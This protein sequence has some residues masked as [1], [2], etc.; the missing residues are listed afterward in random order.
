[1]D[2][3]E[4]LKR[5]IDQSQEIVVFTGAGISTESGVSDYRSQGGIWQRFQPV[6]IQEFM[7]DEDKRELYWQRKLALFEE[8][9]DAKPNIGHKAIVE[10]ERQGKLRALITQNIDGLHQMAGTDPKKI[11]ELHGT[12]LEVICL[13]C[14][15]IHSWEHAY[16]RLKNGEKAPKCEKCQGLLKPNTISFGQTLDTHVLEQ[17]FKHASQCDMMLALGSSLVVE[18]A[19][20]MPRMAKESG[21]VLAIITQSDTPLDHLADLKIE[22]SIGEILSQAICQSHGNSGDV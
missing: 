18:P 22:D 14:G 19:A 13:S 1:M 17:S 6:M 3:I 9:K 7:A 10:L 8:N 4:Q 20:S 11:L 5:F 21:A 12:S 15:D 16:K 2:P